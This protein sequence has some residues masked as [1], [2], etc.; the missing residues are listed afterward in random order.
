MYI[1]A[2]VCQIWAYYFLFYCS[3]LYSVV[4]IVFVVIVIVAVDVLFELRKY[5]FTLAYTER[6]AYFMNLD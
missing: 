4:V 6:Q 5:A 1:G 2:S 3:F